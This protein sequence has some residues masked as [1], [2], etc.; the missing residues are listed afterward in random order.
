MVNIG[1]I[2]GVRAIVG[3]SPG[4]AMTH[5]HARA[6]SVAAGVSLSP[7]TRSIVVESGDDEMKERERERVRALPPFARVT[8]GRRPK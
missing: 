2:G 7:L 8:P 5:R 4:C 3:R 1:W 6:L